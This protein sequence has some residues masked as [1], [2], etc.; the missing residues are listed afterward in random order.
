M[1]AMIT[2]TKATL[3]RTTNMDRGGPS[4]SR[5]NIEPFSNDVAS[6]LKRNVQAHLQAY[7]ENAMF[8]FKCILRF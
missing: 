6:N 1:L 5:L 2:A 3:V 4:E 7:Q 8:I